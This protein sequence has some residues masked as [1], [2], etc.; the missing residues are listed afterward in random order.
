MFYAGI[1]VAMDKHDCVVLDSDGNCIVEV[2]TFKNNRDGFKTLKK[3]LLSCSRNPKKIKVGLEST[4]HYSDNLLAFLNSIGFAP[5]LF[6]PLHTN[7]FR[8]GL[9]LR[10]TKTDHVDAHTIATM[11]R[12]EDLKSYS[13]QSYHL[14]ELKSLTRYRSALVSDCSRHKVTLVRLCQILFP[15]LKTVVSALHVASVYALLSELPSADKIAKC[16][17]THLTALLSSASKGHYSRDKAIE[18]RDAARASIGIKSVVKELELQQTIEL[19]QIYQQQIEAVEEQINNLM[20]EIDSP[21]TSIPGIANRMAAVILAETNNFQDF[22]RAEQVLA[23]AG[24]EPSVYQS[25]QLTSTHS[26]MVKRGSKYLRYAIFN[27][28]KYVCH[29]DPTFRSY[30]AKKRAEGK[31]YNVAVSHAAKKLTRVMFHLVKTNKEF[32]PQA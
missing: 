19:I 12:T 32:V 25:G 1:D 5:V 24:L 13:Q 9:S 7:L 17:L 20:D 23:F 6:N 4:G 29:W 10:K 21:I 18:I 11:L 15:E 26:K 30:L 31:P 16:N 27:A 3:V 14:A 8:K 2:F 28:T 22:E